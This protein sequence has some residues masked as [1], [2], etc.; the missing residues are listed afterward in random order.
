MPLQVFSTKQFASEASI[1][2]FDGGWNIRDAPDQVQPNESPD[3]FNVT[4]DERGGVLSRL[5]LSRLNSSAMA[6]VGKK[7]IYWQKQQMDVI[8]IGATLYK[9]ADHV[10]FTSFATLSTSAIV[11]ICEFNG[12]LVV[13]HP[14]DGV[15]TYDGTTWTNRSTTVKGNACANWQNKVWVL[16]DPALPR[17]FWWSN[18]GRP[19]LWTTA[20]DFNEIP[21][22]DGRPLTC[23]GSGNGMDV[24]GRPGL[25]IY[26]Q[27][28]VH[29]INSATTGSY[30]TLGTVGGAGGTMA[31]VPMPGGDTY[32]ITDTGIWKCD[33]TSEPVLAS[34]KL[35]PLFTKDGL[36]PTKIDLM[37][38]GL[39][40]DRAV[41]SLARAGAST[42]DLVLEHHPDDGWIVPHLF[43]AASFA[44]WQKDLSSLHS[45]NPNAAYV[46][47]TFKG[48]TDEGANITSRW[49][50]Y[51]V[52]LDVGREIRVRQAR[53]WGRGEFSI[54]V[55]TDFQ[56]GDGV[57]YPIVFPTD[58]G[59]WG[60][61]AWGTFIWGPNPLE[62][63]TAIRSLGV[64][65]HMSFSM[66]AITSQSGAAR[67]ILG[68]PAAEVGA[69]AFFGLNLMRLPLGGR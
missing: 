7:L 68:G 45:L 59:R 34:A 30:T 4:P 9:T 43:G 27:R 6:G 5:G 8:Q 51:W 66:R 55:H 17:R 48:G 23:F 46:W 53:V 60:T 18:A 20:T 28:S 33:G 41:F 65:R 16:G 62:G 39:W 54:H 10:T 69:V 49:Q 26:K 14:I 21:E 58:F 19:D 67:P 57:E 2:V 3:C 56:G 36:D 47:D 24:S 32:S 38:A 11:G 37:C 15:F 52:P 61:G 64:A 25:I 35:A 13:A 1:G 40:K 22:P 63:N 12:E 50:T 31:A 29:R 42:N 44:Q